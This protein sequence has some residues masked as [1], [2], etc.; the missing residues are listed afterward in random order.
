MFPLVILFVFWLPLARAST[1][2]DYSNLTTAIQAA[3][4]ARSELLNNSIGIANLTFEKMELN[5]GAEQKLEKI[6]SDSEELAIFREMMQETG[7]G[8]WTT[9]WYKKGVK[10]RYDMNVE[11]QEEEDS[12]FLPEN[13]NVA[14]DPEKGIHYNELSKEAFINRPPLQATN[15]FNLKNNFDI[16][17][18]YKF[19]NT[20]LPDILALWVE[21]GVEPKYSEEYIDGVRCIKLEFSH[22]KTTSMGKMRKRRLELWV[23]PEMSYSLVRAQQFSNMRSPGEEPVLIES[24]EAKYQESTFERIWLLKD[25]KIVNKQGAFHEELTASFHNTKVGVEIPEET[26]TFE[27]LGVPPGTKIYDRSLGGQPLQ[28][29]YKSFPIGEIDDLSEQIIA[30][31]DFKDIDISQIT[32]VKGV[33][34]E[35]SIPDE[36]T[37]KEQTELESTRRTIASTSK[38]AEKNLYLLLV[39]GSVVFIIIM[40]LIITHLRYPTS[41]KE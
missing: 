12:I 24:Y 31:Q 40:I 2:S 7:K 37:I 15:P 38:N 3:Y 4:Q 33:G 22:E 23:A 11:V 35:E 34:T 36:I 25:V 14:V 9:T 18:L 6:F 1:I 17:R 5:E 28:Y 30:Q 26:F 20:E 41:D 32:E 39:C 13:K 10:N 8:T 16:T 19:N 21:A 29:Y 27:G